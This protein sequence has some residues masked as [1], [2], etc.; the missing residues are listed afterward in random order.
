MQYHKLSSETLNV[1]QN[2][3]RKVSK[4]RTREIPEQDLAQYEVLAREV[5]RGVSGRGRGKRRGEKETGAS[6]VQWN[7]EI[8]LNHDTDDRL[9]I[10]THESNAA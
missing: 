9:M 1:R 10:V 7:E 5:V 6:Y 2:S 4:K 3:R 8:I